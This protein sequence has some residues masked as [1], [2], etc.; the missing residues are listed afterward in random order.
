VTDTIH[1]YD[2]DT[3]QCAWCFSQ[4]DESGNCPWGSHEEEEAVAPS[5]NEV[6]NALE[7]SEAPVTAEQIQA[8]LER[9]VAVT[10]SVTAIES[11]LHRLHS[12]GLVVMHWAYDTSPPK[13]SAE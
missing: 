5:A 8:E 2:T 11:D 9:Q 12:K 13:W 4:V 3:S 6:L 7:T 10:Y 1:D